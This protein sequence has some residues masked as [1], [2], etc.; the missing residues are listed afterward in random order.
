MMATFP[1]HEVE[2]PEPKHEE[3]TKP[4]TQRVPFLE[5]MKDKPAKLTRSSSSDQMSKN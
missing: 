4:K 1:K 5:Q 2:K 3:P